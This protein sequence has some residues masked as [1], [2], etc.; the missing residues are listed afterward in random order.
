VTAAGS[1]II[2]LPSSGQEAKYIVGSSNEPTSQVFIVQNNGTEAFAGLQANIAYSGE[3]S[4]WLSA[5]FIGQEVTLAFDCEPNVVSEG[6]SYATVTFSDA[7][8]VSP[9]TYV[10]DLYTSAATLVPNITATPGQRFPYLQHGRYPAR[11]AGHGRELHRVD[12][13]PWDHHS[14]S[15]DRDDVGDRLVCVRD[16]DHLV[17]GCERTRGGHVFG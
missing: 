4:G 17:S 9:A 8:A 7:N 10:V 6:V 12:C 15:H 16:R 14:E 2:G 1:A 3:S 11:A 13:G 5:S